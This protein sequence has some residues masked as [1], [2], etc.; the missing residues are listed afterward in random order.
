MVKTVKIISA[1]YYEMLLI[2]LNYS[3]TREHE[4]ILQASIVDTL[5]RIHIQ[6]QMNSQRKHLFHII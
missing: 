5:R 4:C 6:V 3:V 2:I 1:S